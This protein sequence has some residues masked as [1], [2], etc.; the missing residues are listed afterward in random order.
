MHLINL[1]ADER[2][3]QAERGDYR[4]QRHVDNLSA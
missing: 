1:A 4:A 3:T 2:V